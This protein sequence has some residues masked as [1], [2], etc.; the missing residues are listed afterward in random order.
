MNLTVIS[1]AGLYEPINIVHFISSNQKECET[2]NQSVPQIFSKK[3]YERISLKC[4]FRQFQDFKI[5]CHK[6]PIVWWPTMSSCS[7]LFFANISILYCRD[8]K[9][10]QKIFGWKMENSS[11]WDF[12]KLKI[13]HVGFF[14]KF[15]LSHANHIA[16]INT[17][18][19]AIE[20]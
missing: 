19:R 6:N 12:I 4:T 2:F 20:R 7:F 11:E 9:V 10:I 5:S 15:Q 13:R 8:W 1:L 18:E 3:T 17:F 14:K 16:G